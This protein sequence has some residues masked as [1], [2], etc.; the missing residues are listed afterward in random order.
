VRPSLV[1]YAIQRAA[2]VEIVTYFLSQ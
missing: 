1:G 2:Q